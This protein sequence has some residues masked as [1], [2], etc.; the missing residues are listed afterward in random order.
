MNGL[1]EFFWFGKKWVIDSYLSFR[2]ASVRFTTLGVRRLRQILGR[3]CRRGSACPG[4]GCLEMIRKK[5]NFI[6]NV[7]RTVTFVE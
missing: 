4:N 7:Y 3:I 1:F 2:E 5:W 6:I